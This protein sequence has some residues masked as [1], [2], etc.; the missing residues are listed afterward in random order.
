MTTN[1]A[2][3][4][5]ASSSRAS[6]SR[7]TT[8]A[9]GRNRVSLPLASDMGPRYSRWLRPCHIARHARD[10]PQVCREHVTR[11][12]QRIRACHPRGAR[13]GTQGN[14]RERVPPRNG[15]TK[16]SYRDWCLNASPRRRRAPP[17]SMLPGSVP[18]PWLPSHVSILE[19]SGSQNVPGSRRLA[20]QN[21]FGP[22]AVP[23]PRPPPMEGRGQVSRQRILRRSLAFATRRWRRVA[24]SGPR[25]P[26][27]SSRHR[28]RRHRHRHRHRHRRRRHRRHG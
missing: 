1:A 3:S 20:R 24:R 4:S 5:R 18:A 22:S 27:Q 8:S 26:C 7:W 6:C 15:F 21:P 23:R 28:H 9:D 12:Y 13:N 2:S 19:V 16:Q 11:V 25:H 17:G 10:A 14:P